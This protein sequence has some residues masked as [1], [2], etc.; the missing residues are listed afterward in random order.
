MPNIHGLDLLIPLYHPNI[1]T[2]T[3]HSAS[4]VPSKQHTASPLI[5]GFALF[6]FLV[7]QEDEYSVLTLSAGPTLT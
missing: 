3:H 4:R 7:V 1:I 2:H 5:C 6:Q